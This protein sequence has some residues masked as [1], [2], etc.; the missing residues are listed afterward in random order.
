MC[1]EHSK[2]TLCNWKN[3]PEGPAALSQ[4]HLDWCI[5]FYKLVKDEHVLKV[6]FVDHFKWE[7]ID[8][9]LWA[10]FFRKVMFDSSDAVFNAIA[11]N[12]EWMKGRG[13]EVSLQ[14]EAHMPRGFVVT[15]NNALNLLSVTEACCFLS[16]STSVMYGLVFHLV[17]VLD[18]HGNQHPLSASFYQGAG[19]VEISLWVVKQYAHHLATRNIKGPFTVIG[20]SKNALLRQYC[21]VCT[22]FFLSLM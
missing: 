6:M 19:G 13:N 14:M 18:P 3:V 12:V 15:F 11:K 9:R 10:L 5:N 22:L 8:F 17:W 4:A 7:G 20:D 1:L 16:T 21:H 2:P